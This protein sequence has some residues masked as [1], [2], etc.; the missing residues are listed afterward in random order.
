MMGADYSG[1]WWILMWLSMAVF[2]SF[3]VIGVAWL[4]N[5]LRNN[6]LEGSPDE[7]LKRRFAAGEIDQAQY[8]I[9][10]DEIHGRPHGSTGTTS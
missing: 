3:A 9:L 6:K 7:T 1:G 5:S 10:S 2:W 8:R 4:M